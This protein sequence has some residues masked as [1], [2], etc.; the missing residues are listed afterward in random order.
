[1]NVKKVFPVTILACVFLASC[2]SRDDT[3][4]AH[5]A[6]AENLLR[7]SMVREARREIDS[8]IHRLPTSYSVRST[9]TSLYLKYELWS[10]AARQIEQIL[11]LSAKGKLD[12]KLSR[13]ELAHW[14]LTLGLAWQNAREVE[15]AERAFESALRAAPQSAQLMNALAYFYAEEGIKLNKALALARRAVKLAPSNGAIVDTLGWVEYK[16]GRYKSAART[17]VK[18]V[19]LMPDDATLRYH[20]AAAYSKLGLIEEARIELNKALLLD[21]NHRESRTLLRSLQIQLRK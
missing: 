15:R 19:R 21:P 2:S 20:L 8:L 14:R 7:A 10:D 9:A 16:L 18:A 5:L 17:L 11:D 3:A 1:M 13:E 4:K 12:K 6:R